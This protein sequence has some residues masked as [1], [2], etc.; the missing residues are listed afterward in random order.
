[1][2]ALTLEQ[3]NNLKEIVL[4]YLQGESISVVKVRL[5]TSCEDLKASCKSLYQSKNLENADEDPF[6]IA[7]LGSLNIKK[8][9]TPSRIQ[10]YHAKL[11]KDCDS[12]HELLTRLSHDGHQQVGNLLR[13]IDNT[14]PSRNW[15]LFFLLG[16]LASAGLG[17]LFYFKR[18]YLQAMGNWFLSTFPSVVRWLSLLRNLPLLG[19]MYNGLGLLWTWNNSITNSA[20][21]SHKKSLSLAFRTATSVLAMG[22]YFLCFQAEGAMTAVAISLFI[23]SSSI[24][25]FRSGFNLLRNSKAHNCLIDPEGKGDWETL[26]QYER[27]KNYHKRAESALWVKLTAA[28]FTTIAVAIWNCFPPNIIITVSCMA[29]IWLT[30]LTKRSILTTITDSYATNLQ[31]N[32]R[33]IEAVMKPELSPSHQNTLVKLNQK[34][35]SLGEKEK[36]L[37]DRE[38]MIE[39]RETWAAI[40]EQTVTDTLKAVSEGLSSPAH[41][42]FRLQ[43][44]NKPNEILR[45]P[46]VETPPPPLSTVIDEKPI[47][48]YDMSD[49]KDV[50]TRPIYPAISH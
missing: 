4:N 26:A 14:R 30:A 48:D 43:N 17:S 12:L 24:E 36:E 50:V 10:S 49:A 19:I 44:G 46:S 7:I 11:L 16:T 29:F 38:I 45:P 22:A 27:A 41:A 18:N 15:S 3:N 40:R 9:R 25:V 8:K 34:Q 13:L 31:R 37:L 2:P 33:N 42:L 32:V 39:K 35:R 6:I 1:M 47:N 28:I 5:Q 21:N 23:L 20:S